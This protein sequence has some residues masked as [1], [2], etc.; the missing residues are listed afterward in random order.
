MVLKISIS[1][2]S[3]WKQTE[4]CTAALEFLA[5]FGGQIPDVTVA[6]DT[7]MVQCIW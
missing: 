1:C 2:Q 3:N 4:I 6:V 7:A 5:E